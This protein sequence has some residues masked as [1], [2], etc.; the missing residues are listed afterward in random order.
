MRMVVSS[1]GSVLSS[2]RAVASKI[3]SIVSMERCCFGLLRLRN[4]VFLRAGIDGPYLI[5]GK[6]PTS[7]VLIAGPGFASTRHTKIDS[8]CTRMYLN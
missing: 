6:R 3:A 4:M 7:S 5:S 8:R 2:M 1:L